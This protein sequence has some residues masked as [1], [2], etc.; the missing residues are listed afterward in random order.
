MAT[1]TIT[2]CDICGKDPAEPT[3][4]AARGRA[5]TVDLCGAHARELDAALR[6]FLTRAAKAKATGAARVSK[7]GKAT[8]AARKKAS[9]GKAAAKK[10]AG[11][12]A[13]PGAAKKS[14]RK[15]AKKRSGRTPDTAAVRAW[16]R[17]NGHAVGDKGVIRAD[18]LAAY[19]AAAG[20]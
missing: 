9:A 5:A 2:T 17:E 10:R 14:A 16:A 20:K 4:I 15:M 3:K 12:K 6:P 1:K 13:V 19:Q 8:K 18:V 7:A 11:R